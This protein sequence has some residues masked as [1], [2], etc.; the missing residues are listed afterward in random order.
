MAKLK[1]CWRRLLLTFALLLTIIGKHLVK[2]EACST[3]QF[4][5]A[6]GRCIPQTWTCD[7]EN[8]CGDFSDEQHCTATHEPVLKTTPKTTVSCSETEFACSSGR[9][10]P[11]RWQCD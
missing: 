9:C 1:C 5:C 11:A 8:D 2:G 10:I 6:K 4:E 7:G 3:H